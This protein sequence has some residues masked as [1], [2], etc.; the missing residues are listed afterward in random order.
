ML[1]NVFLKNLSL[2]QFK[3]QAADL[4]QQRY[5]IDFLAIL[6]P[7]VVGLISEIIH[8]V[9]SR[10]VDEKQLLQVR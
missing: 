6:R 7:T 3:T 8:E 1:V 2:T 9:Q 5:R 4:F 10:V